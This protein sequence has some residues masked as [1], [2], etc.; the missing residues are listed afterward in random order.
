MFSASGYTNLLVF[1][2]NYRSA[3][4]EVETYG[5]VQV[6]LVYSQVRNYV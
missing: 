1:L 2:S 5:H 3:L 4:N 6:P